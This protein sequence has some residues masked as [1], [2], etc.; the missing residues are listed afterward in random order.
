M[1]FYMR[2]ALENYP[3]A[4]PLKSLTAG[5]DAI[6]RHL[7]ESSP[8]KLLCIK[9][10]CQRTAELLPGIQLHE[11]VLGLLHLQAY[12][13]LVLDIQVR[14]RLSGLSFVCCLACYLPCSILA[15]YYTTGYICHSSRCIRMHV[16]AY[17][18]NFL[19]RASYQ[20][21]YIHLPT[22]FHNFTHR[23]T[24]LGGSK[25]TAVERPMMWQRNQHAF[26]ILHLLKLPVSIL[27]RRVPDTCLS[28]G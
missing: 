9:R 16:Y 8:M 28:Q 22:R 14:F 11:Q 6:I 19:P 12:V 17:R 15:I 20:K 18:K 13:L 25:L 24:H 27:G 1:P 21:A 4:T 5:L 3:R 2:R 26:C 7:P 23:L 10:V